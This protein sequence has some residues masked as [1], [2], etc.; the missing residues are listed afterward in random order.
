MNYRVVRIVLVALLAVIVIQCTGPI[1]YN[2][3]TKVSTPEP[4]G[5][6]LPSSYVGRFYFFIEKKSEGEKYTTL[7]SVAFD[8]WESFNVC[9]HS[10]FK[11][12]FAK[13]GITV[14]IMSTVHPGF[15]AMIA[16]DSTTEY[17]TEYH[18]LKKVYGDD[19]STE[20]GA[21]K[22]GILVVFTKFYF[23]R[24]LHLMNARARYY[25]YA[26]PSGDLVLV[27]EFDKAYEM[28]AVANRLL[29]SVGQGNRSSVIADRMRGLWYDE[30][31]SYVEVCSLFAE[32]IINQITKR[33]LNR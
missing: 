20:L 25:V 30:K 24:A 22:P 21:M 18:S 14:E 23:V 26:L 31:D 28:K 5:Y 32:E 19:S 13:Y 8:E 9:V 33:C 4:A 11:K 29:S 7:D 15:K 12:L 3:K 6:L 1:Y 17:A 2:K 27:D 10:V 16:G